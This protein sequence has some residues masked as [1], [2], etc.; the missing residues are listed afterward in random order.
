MIMT[1][2]SADTRFSRAH[3]YEQAVHV[4]NI[5]YEAIF[6]ILAEEYETENSILFVAIQ[7]YLQNVNE[8]S[9]VS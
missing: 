4:Y 8:S 3:T 7:Q 1:E 9:N 2:G 6:R 5:F